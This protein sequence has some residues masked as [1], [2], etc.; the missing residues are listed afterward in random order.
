MSSENETRNEAQG[1]AEAVI[2]TGHHDGPVVFMHGDG[3]NVITGDNH[4]PIVQN[5]T[6]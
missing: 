5:I 4:A 2:Q 6:K 3:N 1:G